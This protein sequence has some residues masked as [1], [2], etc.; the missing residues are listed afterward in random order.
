QTL[1]VPDSVSTLSVDLAGAQG[2]YAGVTGGQGGR[3][4]AT[5]A[6]SAGQQLAIY[7]GG[8]GN[9][10][11]STAGNNGA[12]GNFSYAQG[13]G[14]SDI[15]VGGTD[16]TNRVVVAG[17]GGGTGVNGPDGPYWAGGAGGGLTAANG[18]FPNE[19]PQ[20]G[21]TGEGGSQIAGGRAGCWF[22]G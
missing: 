3:V 21:V 9:D 11:T 18:G 13:G 5:L 2:G 10:W 16:L 20:E 1:V 12:N 17:G 19:G 7:V 14:A 15:R 4:Q 22:G 6:V 8:L